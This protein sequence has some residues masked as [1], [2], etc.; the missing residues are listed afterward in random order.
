MKI[1]KK[2]QA[3]SWYYQLLILLLALGLC[4]YLLKTYYL[5]I[6]IVASVIGLKMLWRLLFCRA[7]HTSNGVEFN[8]SRSA[9]IVLMLFFLLMAILMG[10]G[11][12]TSSP[13]WYGYIIPAFVLFVQFA[14]VFQ[15]WSNRNDFLR[16]KDN[17]IAFKDN[18]NEGSI[19]FISLAIEERKTEALEFKMSG[20]ATGPFLVV[21]DTQNQE[22][23]FD[24][25]MMNLNGHVRSIKKH[26]L[27]Q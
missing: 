27:N 10:Y 5:L 22:H 4:L 15:V 8:L 11:I 13:P 25:K 14:N 21:T 9:E 26:I 6:A 2:F 1:Y 12:Y 20:E 19:E 18:E 3:L 17:L 24:L 23:A 7:K 16:I